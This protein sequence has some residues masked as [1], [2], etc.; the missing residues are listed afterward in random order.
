MPSLLYDFGVRFYLA[1]SACLHRTIARALV[2]AKHRH[3]MQFVTSQR[4]SQFLIIV[5]AKRGQGISAR[6]GKTPTATQLAW[7]LRIKARQYLCA[8]AA[9]LIDTECHNVN[10]T[11]RIEVVTVIDMLL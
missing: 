9:H 10:K 3:H 2:V 4:N 6:H 5:V 11:S 1:L 7:R 8:V